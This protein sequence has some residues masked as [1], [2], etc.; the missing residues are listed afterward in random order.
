MLG[1]LA[2]VTHPDGEIA[3]L[4]DSAF[5]IA[6]PPARLA[7]Y[8]AALGI[9]PTVPKEP[10]V[11]R[12]AGIARLEDGE[13]CCI[14]TASRPWP[15]HQPGHAHCDALSFE[16]S[17]RG[18]RVITD[19]GVCEYAPG[20][21]RDLSRATRSHAVVQIGD[22][23]QAEC[24]SAH[25][26]GGRPDVAIV[27]A[28]PGRFVEAVAAGWATPEVLHRRRFTLERGEL[29]IADHFDASAPRARAFLPLAPGLVPALAGQVVTVPLRRG[30][31]LR[32]A[33]PEALAWRVERSPYFPEF[34]REEERAVLVGEGVNVVRAEWRIAA[35]DP[36]APR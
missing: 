2:V 30:G 8:A 29:A 26:I 32:I 3:L 34:G 18:E 6:Q 12:E 36:L 17:V 19:T 23:E 9:A 28:E 4:G 24:W 11:L 16:L 5:G 35:S 7:E 33:L 21:R 25:R 10:G 22:C 27:R 15:E 31:A 1:A 20:A 14:V 13:L